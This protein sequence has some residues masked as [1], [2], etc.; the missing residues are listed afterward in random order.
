MRQKHLARHFVSRRL[1]EYYAQPANIVVGKSTGIESMKLSSSLG[2][3]HWRRLLR[4]YYEEREGHWLTPVELFQPYFSRILAEFCCQAVQLDMAKTGASTP[5]GNFESSSLQIVELG[6][7]QGTNANLI[8]S[9]LKETKPEIYDGVTYTLVD[10]SPTLHRQQ[11]DRLKHGDHYAKVK[12]QLT[13]L[14][15]VAEEK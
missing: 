10:S 9:Y 12:F 6:C 15:D 8:L 4:K 2:E 1:A 14:A 11:M 5:R 3:W 13:D 7:G